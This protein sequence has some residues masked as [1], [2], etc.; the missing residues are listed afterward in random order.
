MPRRVLVFALSLLAFAACAAPARADYVEFQRPNGYVEPQGVNRDGT[1]LAMA[2]YDLG[3]PNETHVPFLWNGTYTRLYGSPPD[4]IRTSA[5]DINDQGRSIGI[6]A[7][8]NPASNCSYWQP[9]V[10][11]GTVWAGA[12]VLTELGG[13][14][15]SDTGSCVWTPITQPVA[16]NNAGTVLGISEGRTVIAAAGSTSV[17]EVPAPCAGNGIS[18]PPLDIN[19][20][21]TVLLQCS[22]GAR[23]VSPVGA[24]T[25]I[26]GFS[27]SMH[28]LT[29]AGVV[30]GRSAN[31]LPA[32]AIGSTIVE[33]QPLPGYQSA[34]ANA[35]ADDGTVVGQSN[36]AGGSRATLWRPDG[37][38]VDLN[39]MA[40]GAS[41]T[42]VVANAISSDGAYIAGRVGAV[43]GQT[44]VPVF[45]L[46]QGQDTLDVDITANAADGRALGEGD[47]TEADTFDVHVTLKNTSTTQAIKDLDYAGGSPLTID[48]RSIA[49]IGVPG[50]PAGAAPTTL[51]PGESRTFDYQLAALTDGVAAAT[52]KVTG[53][54]ADGAPQE[55]KG[56]LK[57]TVTQAAR[58][59]AALAQWARLQGMD[60]LMLTLARKVYKGWDKRGA[61]MQKQL[62]KVLSPAQRKRWFGTA[63][64]DVIG[65]IDVARALLMGRA[66]SATAAQF[67]KGSIGGV[68][69][70]QMYDAYNKAFKEQVGK[71]AAKYVKKWGDLGEGAKDQVRQAWGESALAV[72]YIMNSASQDQRQQAEAMVM[73]FSDG[74]V[75]DTGSYASWTMNEAS[76]LMNDGQAV[77]YA[78]ANMDQGAK[79]FAGAVALP[80]ERDAAKR[81]SLAKLADTQ[82]LLWE[83]EMAKLD[84]EWLNGGAEIIADTFV[85]GAVAKV[86][87]SPGKVVELTKKG[88]ALINFAKATE[89]LDETGKLSKGVKAFN[90]AKNGLGVGLSGEESAALLEENALKSTEGATLVQSSDYGNVYKL[91]N[92]GGVPEVTL[93]AK[94]AI[95]E[96]VE[97]DFAQT[98]G[99]DIELAEVLKPSTELRK[100]GSVAKLEMTGQKTGKPAMVDAGMPADALGEAVLWKPKVPP[101]K[102]PGFKNLSKARQAAAVEEY[103]NALKANADWKA[104]KPDSKTAKLKKLI[105]KEGEVPLDDKPWPGG[106]SDV[107]GQPAPGLQRFVKAEFELVKVEGEYADAYLIRVKKYQ[108]V[109][110]DMGRGG[111]VVNTK[112]VVNSTK[113][114]AQGVDADAVGMAK[115]IGR[116]AAGKPVLGPLTA[117]EREF[118]MKR[119]VARNVKARAAGVTTDLAEHGATLVMDDADA[120]H[121]GFLLPKFGV[122]FLASEVGIP[123][124]QRI[125][126][127]VAPK[128]TSPELMFL[129]MW[130]AV[131]KEGGFGQHAVVLTKDV[132]YLGEVPIA[133]W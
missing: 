94:A 29:A 79:D 30:L 21:G 49:H 112:T 47:L 89:I 48:G 70:D 37:T 11:R 92:V 130:E 80:F 6:S 4:S 84:A 15:K 122:P 88:A 53:K 32:K 33:L 118:V 57:L 17:S 66:P 27:A 100:P 98:F 55:A 119:Y 76:N 87:T 115:V 81:A 116:D 8:N 121:A 113:A 52:V 105:G 83:R 71:G 28:G 22:G 106:P 35:I 31:G 110:K 104:P 108:I 124:L 82:P 69:A 67:P 131:H 123:F 26:P 132:R 91:P 60:Q 75:K 85:G 1:V 51:G 78:L 56:S 111:K 9:L 96:G 19:D 54:A 68:S 77:I 16:I 93:D 102:I 109:V 74:V 114:L 13:L 43:G 10:Q 73:T 5:F 2:S 45:R 65:Q 58:L 97:S 101:S 86:V 46:G 61:A 107:P 23:L 18:Q 127:F 120:A 128:G 95:L 3:N 90:G 38:P 125:A 7:Y 99:R 50:R 72:N 39:T 126:K 12:G 25:D 62:R 41:G 117:A 34:Y 63:K 59:N 40:P 103:E 24:I 42:L 36:A 14:P 20:G 44:D 64:K 133:Q 129:N